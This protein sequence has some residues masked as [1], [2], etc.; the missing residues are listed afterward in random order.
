M[1]LQ[2]TG[3]RALVTGSTAGIGYAIAHGLAAEGAQVVITGR[4]QASVDGA[5][6]R[7][8]KEVVAMRA[9]MHDGHPNRSE[10]FDLKHDHG[11]M[12][13]IEFVVQYLVLAHSADHPELLENKGNIALLGRAAQAGLIDA[14]LARRAADAYRRYRALQHKLRLDDAS[15][16]RLDPALV[17]DERSA[18]VSLWQSVFGQ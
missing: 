16:A 11:G 7:L 9:K 6:A 14:A 10:R 5:L 3:K 12:V 1:D 17:E 8:R 15:Y 13:D 2:I 18:V 4:T